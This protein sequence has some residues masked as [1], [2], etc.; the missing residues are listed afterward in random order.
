M[1]FKSYFF[2]ENLITP[3]GQFFRYIQVILYL[4]L[5]FLLEKSIQCICTVLKI[6]F[7]K[8]P[9]TSMLKMTLPS[10]QSKTQIWPS[11]LPPKRMVFALLVCE[12]PLPIVLVASPRL[13]AAQASDLKS[14]TY[15]YTRR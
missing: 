11:F 1:I 14:G 8:M 4:L 7:R 10:S 13:N 5:S 3:L 15:S 9:L 2:P 6:Q 12:P